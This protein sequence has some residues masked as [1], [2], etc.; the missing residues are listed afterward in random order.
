MSR[1]LRSP[2]RIR[3]ECHSMQVRDGKDPYSLRRHS[4]RDVIQPQEGERVWRNRTE[5][6][7]HQL[8]YA[9]YNF[10]SPIDLFQPKCSGLL[11]ISGWATSVQPRMFKGDSHSPVWQELHNGT[12]YDTKAEWKSSFQLLHAFGTSPGPTIPLL[13]TYALNVVVSVRPASRE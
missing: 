13:R 4:Q 3:I 8:G 6:P 7:K 2:C 12:E 11:Q 10:R 5:P 1:N 9:Q